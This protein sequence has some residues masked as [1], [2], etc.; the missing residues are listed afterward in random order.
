[1]WFC[2]GQ[3][4]Q[5]SFPWFRMTAL[6]K[7]GS[8]N[9][10]F[11]SSRAQQRG[12]AQWKTA[13]LSCLSLA[14]FKG[15]P[16]HHHNIYTWESFPTHCKKT[17]NWALRERESFIDGSR[18]IFHLKGS[19]MF[20]YSLLIWVCFF[21]LNCCYSSWFCCLRWVQNQRFITYFHCAG[22]SNWLENALQNAMIITLTLWI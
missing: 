6:T 4:S 22:K 10:W 18:V 1:M 20:Y 3:P 16:Y 11:P 19:Q 13:E 21:F 5:G 7:R 8:L 14:N 9:S 15:A 12:N 2:L 17:E